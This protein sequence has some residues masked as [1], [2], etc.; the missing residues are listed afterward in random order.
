MIVGFYE[1]EGSWWFGDNAKCD[2]QLL[3]LIMLR[4]FGLTTNACPLNMW[5]NVI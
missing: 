4:V 3:N 1:Y 5:L 2:M